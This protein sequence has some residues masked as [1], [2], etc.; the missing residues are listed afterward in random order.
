MYAVLDYTV[1]CHYDRYSTNPD[2]PFTQK[3]L[4]T[5][6]DAR[7]FLEVIYTMDIWWFTGGNVSNSPSFS[8]KEALRNE[9]KIWMIP[10]WSNKGS[11]IDT[12]KAGEGEDPRPH[13]TTHLAVNSLEMENHYSS[14][15][16]TISVFDQ[17]DRCWIS[18][19][20]PWIL[21]DSTWII[22][23]GSRVVTLKTDRT[24]YSPIIF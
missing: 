24:F 21:I 15:I 13:L 17:I 12:P 18:N 7:K 1:P 3:T 9:I 5:C 8:D 16:H 19:I 6:D 23:S 4:G 14:A 22:W 11:H 20:N 2:Q 10:S